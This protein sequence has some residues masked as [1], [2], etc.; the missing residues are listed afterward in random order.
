MT[1]DARCPACGLPIIGE[2]TACPSCSQARP[3]RSKTLTALTAATLLGLVVT[4]A[5]ER[6][7]VALYGAPDSGNYDDEDGDGWSP[8]DG[9]CDDTDPDIHP[10]A[11]ETAGDG[12][13]SNCNDDDDT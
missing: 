9:D 7:T 10:D 8:V 6:N 13:D 4:A 2:G 5:C 1:L 3:R 11:E 12:I